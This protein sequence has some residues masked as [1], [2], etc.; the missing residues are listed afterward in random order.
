MGSL[1]ALTRILYDVNVNIKIEPVEGDARRYRYLFKSVED[2]VSEPDIEPKNKLIVQRS[3]STKTE[4]FNMNS[5]T[6]CKAFPWHF[7]MNEDLELV[8]LGNNNFL[9]TVITYV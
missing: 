8:Q 7:I 9:F 5:S 6:F 1:K 3:I 4:D 2:V